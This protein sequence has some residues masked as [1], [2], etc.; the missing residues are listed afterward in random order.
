VGVLREF[1]KH[2]ACVVIAIKKCSEHLKAAAEKPIR[3]CV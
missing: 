3:F 2:H 1:L